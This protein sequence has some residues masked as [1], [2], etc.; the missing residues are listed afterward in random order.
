MLIARSHMPPFHRAV[1][2]VART[3]ISIPLYPTLLKSSIRVV[4]LL[5]VLL[6]QTGCWGLQWLLRS[7]CHQWGCVRH[8]RWG[9][10]ALG[11]ICWL[12]WTSTPFFVLCC[13]QIIQ[14]WRFLQCSECIKISRAFR[15]CPKKT[16]EFRLSSVLSL[17]CGRSCGLG[18]LLGS[19]FCQPQGWVIQAN[20]DC[21]FYP[22]SMAGLTFCGSW[23]ARTSQ[24]DSRAL[25]KIFLSV[26]GCQIS[27]SVGE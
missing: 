18:N 4:H 24:L 6:S 15:H 1:H 23:S 27:V 19:E 8:H 21:S 10:V 16:G 5:R 3:M 9:F 12:L 14:Q 7:I 20:W 26:D 2:W 22:F 25:T 13:S 11:C 17:F